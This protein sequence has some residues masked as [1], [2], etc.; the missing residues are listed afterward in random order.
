MA[1][2]LFDSVQ[3][4][5]P[6]KNRFNLQCT[7][8]LSLKIGSIVPVQLLETVPGDLFYLR[9]EDFVRLAPMVFPIFSKLNLYVHHFFVP[10]R[11]L[12]DM[13]YYEEMLTGGRYGQSE[14]SL[15][16]LSF[17]DIYKMMDFAKTSGYQTSDY[18]NGL[19]QSGSLWD[20]LGLP[21]IKGFFDN[22]G[23]AA[24]S[25]RNE[26]INM[27]PFMAY[28]RIY[29]DYYRDQ[30]MHTPEFYQVGKGEFTGVDGSKFWQLFDSY[31]G[32]NVETKT[33]NLMTL[34]QR[35]YGKDYFTSA[36]STP[37]RGADVEID[38]SG[39]SSVYGTGKAVSSSAILDDPTFTIE[40]YYCP[41]K[42]F[43]P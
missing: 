22:V 8:N 4:S 3:F 5:L 42:L 21:D 25:W 10:W 18:L 26:S 27:L 15:P 1:N 13:K 34:R 39:E 31:D 16:S 30:N 2:Q 6:S 40:K 7:N 28:Q 32:D 29:S 12:V 38:I 19:C 17:Y 9:S 36:L 43:I 37:Q 35:C 14:L 11:V 24:A 23:S 20:Y 41:L 33:M